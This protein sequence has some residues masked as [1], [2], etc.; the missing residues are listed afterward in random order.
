M[1]FVSKC[2]EL[3]YFIRHVDES[4]E[5]VNSERQSGKINI[6]TGKGYDE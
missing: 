1:D 4:Y 2:H 5:K 3:V 6:S